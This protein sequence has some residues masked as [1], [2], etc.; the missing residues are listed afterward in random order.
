MKTILIPAALTLSH[1]IQPFEGLCTPTRAELS[2]RRDLSASERRLQLPNFVVMFDWGAIRNLLPW[3]L[4]ASGETPAWMKRLC[5]S[6]Y[7]WLPVDESETLD[8]LDEFDLMVRLF[9]FSPWRPYFA[10]RFRSQFG[11]PPFDPL[12]VGLGIFL[13]HHQKWDWACLAR[14]L[15]SPTRGL[16]YCL[17]LGFAPSDLPVE[18]T[19]RTPAL[20]QTQCGA[21]VAFNETD[22]DWFADCHIVPMLFR[23]SSLVQGLMAYQLIPTHSTF[24]GDPM[25]QGVSLSTDCQLISSR[26]HMQCRHPPRTFRTY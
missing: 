4:P 22:A 8:G 18:S 7:Q 23:E 1:V 9:D 20:Q 10:Q 21:S 24:A 11:P 25:D 5:R 17:R 14:E 16:D 15:R 12:S 13:A 6:Y 2:A 19:F 3:R 26:S